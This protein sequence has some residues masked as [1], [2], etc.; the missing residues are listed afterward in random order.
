M[1]EEEKIDRKSVSGKGREGRN[2][3][4][5]RDRKEECL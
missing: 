1:K 2:G 4:G 5:R 3:R